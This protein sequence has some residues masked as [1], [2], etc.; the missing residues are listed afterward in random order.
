MQR[1]D[2]AGSVEAKA[3]TGTS[4]DASYRCS[5]PGAG[6]ITRRASPAEETAAAPT[7]ANDTRRARRQA[8]LLM[9]ASG[10]VTMTALVGAWLALRRVF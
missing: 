6:S 4:P 2:M 3:D 1:P 10:I 5:P 7:E 9:V 8:L